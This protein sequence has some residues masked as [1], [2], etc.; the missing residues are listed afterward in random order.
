MIQSG[1]SVKYCSASTLITKPNTFYI[2]IIS[3]IFP[4]NQISC[5]FGKIS[6]EL[7]GHKK[8]RTELILPCTEDIPN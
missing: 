8:G 7:M 6:S 4:T 5:P 1:K 2:Q 3:I